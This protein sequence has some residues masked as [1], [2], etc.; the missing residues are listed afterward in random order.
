MSLSQEEKEGEWYSNEPSPSSIISQHGPQTPSVLPPPSPYSS[1]WPLEVAEPASLPPPSHELGPSRAVQTQVCFGHVVVAFC[2][3]LCLMHCLAILCDIRFQALTSVLGS[4]AISPY[5]FL[6]ISAHV[7][8][9][10]GTLFI[11]YVHSF[12]LSKH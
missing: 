2:I 3:E 1:E 7:Q 4:I 12:T 11:S 8:T 9:V 5:L 10:Y 6:L